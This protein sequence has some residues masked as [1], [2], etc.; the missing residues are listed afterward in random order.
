MHKKIQEH[1]M[2]I[3]TFSFVAIILIGVIAYLV[4]KNNM[5]AVR[6]GGTNSFSN[7][8]RMIV[9]LQKSNVPDIEPTLTEADRLHMLSQLAKTPSV[10]SLKNK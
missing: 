9:L 7:S 8:D 5:P 4:A 3:I 10:P 6:S 2:R 1:S